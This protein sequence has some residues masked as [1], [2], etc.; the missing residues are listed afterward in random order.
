MIN[1][2][3]ILRKLLNGEFVS[4]EEQSSNNNRSKAAASSESG[5]KK[6]NEVAL[7]RSLVI[8]KF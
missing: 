7:F 5:N 6:V 8:D 2:I 1:E 3:Q 4:M